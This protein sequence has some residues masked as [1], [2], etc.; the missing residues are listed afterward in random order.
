M[1]KRMI[2]IL[3]LLGYW[4]LNLVAGFCFTEGGTDQAH[5]LTYFIA[6][7]AL[8][9]S[10]T[11]L[12]MGVYARM[13]VNLA[14]VIATSGAFIQ[15][16]LALWAVYRTVITPTQWLG[17]LIVGIGIVLAVRPGRRSAETVA[18]DQ[19]STPAPT[20]EET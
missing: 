18:A 8:G 6:G 10:S 15:F 14:M 9:I 16:Q 12:L 13:N 11:A 3:L 5:R 2:T 7:N 1:P 19:A 17:I 20:G 4:V